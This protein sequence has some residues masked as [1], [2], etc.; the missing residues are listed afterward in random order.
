M[1]MKITTI[2]PSSV[3]Q[4]NGQ[5]VVDDGTFNFPA[6]TT[7]GIGFVVVGSDEERAMFSVDASGNVLLWSAS[8]NVVAN[9]DTDSKFCIGTSVANPV[10]LKNRLGS[11]KAVIISFWYN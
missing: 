1:G 4:V 11:T 2:N 10:V 9:A 7:G 8:D 5:S 3:Y 6:V